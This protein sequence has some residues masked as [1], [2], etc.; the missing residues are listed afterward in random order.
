MII[1]ITG[2]EGSGKTTISN[3]LA[4]EFGWPEYSLGKIFRAL[5]IEKGM[6][7][8]EFRDIC[9]KD[10]KIDKEIDEY[11]VVLAKKEKDFIIESRTAWH[12]LPESLKIYL[13]VDAKEAAQRILNQI[14]TGT[15]RKGE[16]ANL[17]S[18]ETIMESEKKRKA[19][20]DIRYQKYYGID[21]NDEKNYDFILDTT[22]L[23]IEEVFEKVMEFI[24]KNP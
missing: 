20:D 18:V 15:G 7:L 23:S 3:K 4:R 17:N 21:R 13:K 22:N 11:Q 2:N 9:E 1:A 24:K 6:T 14:K 5:A 19:E 12:F 8:P 10:P 16:D